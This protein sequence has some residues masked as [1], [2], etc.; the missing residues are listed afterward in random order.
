MRRYGYELLKPR[1]TRWRSSARLRAALSVE[2]GVLV[3]PVARIAMANM[4]P[5]TLA[6]RRALG[7]VPEHTRTLALS[8]LHVEFAPFRIRTDGQLDTC[9][10]AVRRTAYE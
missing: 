4:A 6:Q 8:V 1:P 10:A 5:G 7:L 9:W 3:E 2:V